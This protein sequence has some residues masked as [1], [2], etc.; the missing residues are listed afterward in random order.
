MPSRLGVL[1]RSVNFAFLGESPYLDP[2]SAGIKNKN[3]N[4]SWHLVV[5]IEYTLRSKSGRFEIHKSG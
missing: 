5:V 1:E 2:L 4:I 3:K